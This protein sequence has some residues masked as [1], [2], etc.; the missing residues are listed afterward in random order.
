MNP[1]PSRLPVSAAQHGIW[2]GQQLAPRNPS[3]WTAEAIELRGPLHAEALLDSAAEV[4]AHCPALNMQFHFDGETLW[5]QPHAET[6]PPPALHDFSGAVQPRA[7]A[8]AWMRESLAS[9][10]QTDSERPF[11][12]ALLKLDSHHHLWFLQAHHIALDGYGYG[13]LAKAIAARYSARASGQAMPPL[14][15]WSLQH[16]L[17]EDQAYR[18]ST[19]REHDRAF[20]LQRQSHLPAAVTLAPPQALADEVAKAGGMLDAQRIASWQLAAKACGA[21]WGGWL[22]AAIAAWLAEHTGRRDITLGLPVM[23]RIGSAALDIPCMAMNIAPFNLRLTPDDTLAELVRQSED[24]LRAIRPRQRYRYEWLRGDLSRLAGD[25]RLFGPVVNLMPFDRRAPFAGLDARIL[26]ISAGPVE[27]LS[28]NLSLLNTEWRFSLEANPR[29]YPPERLQAL[30][31]SLLHW[32]DKLAQTPPATALAELL[33]HLPPLSVLRGP[34]LARPP[35]DVMAR[36]TEQAASQPDAAALVCGAQTLSYSHLLARIQALAGQLRAQGLQDGERV[37]ILLPRSVDAIVAILATLWAGGCYVP[38]D[39]HGPTARLQMALDDAAPKLALSWRRWAAQLGG[40]ATLCLDEVLPFAPA[41]MRAMPTAAHLPAYLLYT[42]GSTGK[43]NG[44]LVGRGALAH[45]VSSAGQ[46]YRFAQGERML[47]F[48]P[49]HFDASVEEIFL[50]LCHGGALLLRDEAMLESMPAFV[51]AVSGLGADVLDLPTAFWHELAYALTPQL[52]KQLSGVRLVIIGGEAALPERARRWRELL[53]NCVLL[54]SYGPTEASIIATGAI[55][56]GPGAAWD[57]S[58]SLPIGLPRPGVDAVIVDETLRPVPAGEAG[59]LCLLGEALALGYL[60]RPELTARRFVELSALPGS[61]RAYRTGDRV[62][63]RDGQLRFLGRLDQ[64]LK[65]SGLRIDP[66]EVENALLAYPTVREAAVIGLPRADGGHTLAAFLSGEEQTDAA[67][68]RRALADVLPAAAIPD[69]WRWL[70]Q[71]PRNVNGKIDRKQLALQADDALSALTETGE[72][73]PLQ[74]KIMAIWQQVLGVTPDSPSANFFAMGGKSL[75]AIQAANRLSR[76]L[77]REVPV[78]A[79]F[80]HHTVSALAQALSAPAAHRPPAQ[81]SDPFGPLLTIQP[82]ALPALFCLHPAEGLSWCYLSLARHLPGVAIYGLQA[83]GIRGETPESFAAMVDGYIKQIRAIQPRG[84]YRLLGWSL[85]GAL[86]QAMAA[87]LQQTGETVELLALMDS[88][89]AACWRDRPEPTLRDAL[90]TV[91]TVNGELDAGPDGRRLDEEA[92]Y[93]R[94]L[95]VGSP[96]APLGRA[97]LEKL[98]LASWQGMRHFRASQTPRYHGDMLLFR[99][100]HHPADGPQ[101]A[102]WAPYLDGWL[103]VIELDCDHIGMS[104]PHP[105]RRIGETLARRLITG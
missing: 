49:L 91:L 69:R 100:S 22:L 25:E 88:Y 48:A 65:I 58:D 71:L 99:A 60:H 105:M 92:I 78:S 31:Q 83:A 23:N 61:P 6:S 84:P 93:Q 30:W 26:P 57:G 27:D 39:P 51:A 50:A 52:A 80:T 68:L 75:Q 73:T 43:P 44:V 17:A 3:Y 66:A 1:T 20:W 101:T 98:A 63:W 79:L 8:D 29:A 47:Q 95:R 87:A 34:A 5:Q 32:L 72:A 7:A 45:F 24:G 13:L 19:D 85:G 16:V 86:V 28:I 18:T 38:L 104:D 90:V 42:S 55:L 94:L 81:D 46:F 64:E 4:L 97:A 103:E 67:A 56:S 36:L 21:N 53:P 11:R 96:L 10:W 35:Q 54:N 82:G 74:R 12:A 15:D 59:E 76:E 62:V 14:P 9:P 89:P 41:Q 102:D 40:I 33:P 77:E 37:A 70:P 2:M